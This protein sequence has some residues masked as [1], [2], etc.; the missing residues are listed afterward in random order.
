M[1]YQTRATADR[2]P[3]MRR[4]LSRS[5]SR[6]VYRCSTAACSTA[7]ALCWTILASAAPAAA[8]DPPAAGEP[9]QTGAP[10]SPWHTLVLGGGGARGLAHAGALLALEQL[11]YDPP[12]VVGT[13]MGAIVGALYAAGYEPAV[14][15]DIITRENWLERFAAEP[16]AAGPDRAPR[17]P[18]IAFGIGPRRAASGVIPTTGVNQRLV[19]LLFDPGVRARND[20]DALPRRFRAVAADLATG[21]QVVLGRG[22]LPRAVRAS[23]AVPGAFSPVR[24]GERV[25]TDGGVANNLPVSV[26]R[27]LSDLPVIAVNV[28]RPLPEITERAAVEIGVRGLRLLIENV[29]RHGEPPD[30]L[31]VP[32]IAPGF[33]ESRFPADPGDLLQ[34]GFDAVLLQVPP[35]APDG[36]PSRRSVGDAP[37]DVARVV[38]LG[39]DPAL[40]RLARRITAPLVGSY[41]ADAIVRRTIAL[42]HTG[43]YDSVWPS[44]SFADE[45]TLVVDLTPVVRTSV[46]G[47]AHWDNDTGAGGWGALRHLTSLQ[48]PVEV[49]ATAVVHGLSTRGGV[50]AS[51]F[52]SLLPGM[53]WN[54]GVYGGEERVRLFVRDS[55]AAVDSVRRVGAWLGAERRGTWYMSLLARADRLT[56]GLEDGSA[57]PGRHGWSYGPF[58]R[59]SRAP[60]PDPVVGMD[61]VLEVETRLGPLSYSRIHGRGSVDGTAGP[62][63]MALFGDLAWSSRHTPADLRPAATTLL[64]PWLRTGALRSRSRASAGLDLAHPTILDGYVRLRLSGIAAGNDAD[65]FSTASGWRFGGELGAIWPTVV[66]PLTAGIAGGGGGGGWRINLGV[67]AA[68]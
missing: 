65:V 41:D 9:P 42:Y 27:E 59:F 18:R 13:S 54:A 16:L 57:G 49:H 40:R 60:R 15:R 12:L 55:I 26:A 23:M 44:L 10:L 45:V 14:V 47:S 66:G 64:A 56:H 17:R 7:A 52:S 3:G 8:Q 67:G 46:A 43:L 11:G 28:L 68:Y 24:W 31:V 19:E 53:I 2:P 33:S 63:R 4:R 58:A 22:D 61:P 36:H 51:V 6:A 20:F 38:V 39:G 21:E 35:A 37:A 25:L 48:T 29:T 50:D 32:A 30:I 1:T 62:L 34:S 5:L